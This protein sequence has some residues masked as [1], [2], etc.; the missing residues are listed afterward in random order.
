MDRKRKKEIIVTIEFIIGVIWFAVSLFLVIYN[1]V[2]IARYESA[3]DFEQYESFY[4]AGDI[5]RLRGVSYVK[6]TV[7]DYVK[8]VDDDGTVNGEIALKV[9]SRFYNYKMYAFSDKQGRVTCVDLYDVDTIESIQ[10]LPE[11]EEVSFIAK[12]SIQFVI[13]DDWFSMVDDFDID[14]LNREYYL[15]QIGN[16][17]MENLLYAGFYGLLFSSIVI[18]REYHLWKNLKHID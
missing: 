1:F 16:T 10:Q 15:I 14:S 17:R 7:D 2:H 13:N 6:C 12:P 8:Q 18:I 3:M 9:T 11:G 5:D 4:E